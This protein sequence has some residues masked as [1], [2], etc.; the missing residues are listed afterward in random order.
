MLIEVAGVL[1]ANPHMRVRVEGHTDNAGNPRDNLRLS[2][3]RAASVRRF[4]IEH[5]ASPRQ[6]RSRGYG[7]ARP[8]AS[9]ATPRGRFRN[10]RVEF[11]IEGR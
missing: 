3:A 2:R 6:V 11:H 4:L 10:R 7:E 1:R 9:N 8:I 5:G